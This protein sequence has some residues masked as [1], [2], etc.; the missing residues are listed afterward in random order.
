MNSLLIEIILYVAVHG[1]KMKIWEL[2]EL[3]E[4]FLSFLE[5][6]HFS[7]NL[8]IFKS[9]IYRIGKHPEN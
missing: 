6:F 9:L 1:L 3:F 8:K 4:A 5:L 2:S 7:E